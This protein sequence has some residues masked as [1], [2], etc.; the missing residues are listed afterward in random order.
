MQ[1][2]EL[3]SLQPKH[4]P[5]YQC[6]KLERWKISLID[7]DRMIA[8]C[9]CSSHESIVTASMNVEIFIAL[10]G[11]RELRVQK[12]H[13]DTSVVLD[14]E[15]KQFQN[16]CPPIPV[17]KKHVYKFKS[18]IADCASGINT[19][20]CLLCIQLLFRSQLVLQGLPRRFRG[21]SRQYS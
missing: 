2:F 10:A 13:M 11:R 18:R 5:F 8:R 15:V 16:I 4:S 1:S 6:S 20:K 3:T 17:S 7:I 9:L 14:E 12:H 19:P 21:Y